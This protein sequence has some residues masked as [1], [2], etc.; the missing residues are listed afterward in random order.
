MLI[1]IIPYGKGF[2]KSEFDMTL[3]I[4]KE[5]DYFLASYPLFD[6]EICEKSIQEVK[7]AF[8]DEIC[9]LWDEY[10]QTPN[11]NLSAG[12]IK[13]K[14]KLLEYFHP[15]TLEGLERTSSASGYPSFK[16]LVGFEYGFA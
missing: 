11:Q 15:C 12:A 10:T 9:F 16:N 4:W 3:D 1:N 5:E 13:L 7:T 14:E 8:E 2:L 6:I